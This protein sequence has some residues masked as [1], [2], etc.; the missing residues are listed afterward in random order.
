[1]FH[2]SLLQ[3]CFWSEAECCVSYRSQPF[4]LFCKTL[5]WKDFTTFIDIHSLNKVKFL[6]WCGNEMELFE[7]IIL[8]MSVIVLSQKMLRKLFGI[9]VRWV[10]QDILL[11]HE[12]HNLTIVYS[13]FYVKKLQE[14]NKHVKS[15]KT[16]C[17]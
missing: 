17:E 1:M 13:S 11:L 5:G 9:N 12:D 8:R 15:L 10:K 7:D 4:V 3:F 16:W 14:I 6:F 2:V